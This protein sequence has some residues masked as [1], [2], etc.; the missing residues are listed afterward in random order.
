LKISFKDTLYLT[1]QIKRPIK[2]LHA[3]T[4]KNVTGIYV[5]V[6]GSSNASYFYDVPEVPD[7][8][9]D[10]VSVVLIGIDPSGLI[11]AGGGSINFTITIVAYD[12]TG[13]ALDQTTRPVKMD[14]PKKDP[15]AA[16]CGLEL[17]PGDYWN[18]DLSLI[19]DPSGNG[20]LIFYNDTKKIW[21]SGGQFITGC[22]INGVS[23][24]NTVLNCHLDPTKAKRK[25]F[26]TYF[27][28]QESATKF[29]NNGTYTQFSRQINVNPDPIATNFCGVQ[30]GV[31]T[32]SSRSVIE[33][34]TWTVT[35]RT[36]YKGDSLYLSLFQLKTTGL[37]LVSPEGYIH[38]LDC[39][40]LALI[41]PDNEN[42]DQA[43]VSFY[44]R[45]NTSIPGWYDML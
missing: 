31:V 2:F 5:Q 22:C 6:H 36:P 43:L 8:G 1:D 38:Q 14:Q 30:A 33:D 37:G 16:T 23:S 9:S 11:A 26:P 15:A 34:G 17:P 19:E 12:K 3:D 24:Y 21:G 27:Q 7:M 39:N 44:T 4:T 25:L 28:H 13:Q 29:F 45:I 18:W 41:N 32:G 10:T 20:K 42:P 40:V 35:K